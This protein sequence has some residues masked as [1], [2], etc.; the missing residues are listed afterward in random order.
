MR[1]KGSDKPLKQIAHDLNVDA[2]VEGSVA[3]E[4]A[5]VRVSAQLIDAATEKNLWADSY[6]R[7]LTSVIALQGEVARAIAQKINVAL[8]PEEE[9]RLTANRKVN[10]ATYEAYLRGMFWLNKGTPSAAKKGLD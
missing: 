10:P 6:E 7:D 1:Y 3:R 8:R 5:R 4:A 2:L 9:T